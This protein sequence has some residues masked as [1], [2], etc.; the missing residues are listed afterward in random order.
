MN[1]SWTQYL[2]PFIRQRLEGR[3]GLQ[4]VVGNTGWLFANNILRMGVGLLVNIWVTRYLGPEQFGLLSYATAFVFVF[5]SIAAMGLDWVVVRNIVRDPS[6]RDEVLGTT[7][8]L[9]LAGGVITFGL[10]L[11]TIFIVRPTDPITRLLVAI[12]A[13]G[14]VFQ[15]FGTINFWFQSQV[16]SK[17]SVLVKSGAFLVVSVA[18]IALICLEAPLVAFAW[19]GLAEIVLGSVGL[20][21]AYR[22]RG[23]HLM[24]W[25]ATGTM[26]KALLRDCWPLMLTDVVMLAYLRID[27]IMLGE[28]AGN[29]EVGIYS[30]AVLLAETWLFIPMA[31]TSSLFPSVVEA[32]EHGEELFHSRL[33]KYYNLM[34]FLGYAVALPVS[35]IANWIVPLLFGT[36]YANAGPMLTGLIWAG[37]F[38]NLTIARSSYLTVMNWT[39]LHLVTDLLGCALNITLNLILIPRFGGMGAVIASLVAYWAVAHGACFLFKPLFKTGSMLTK[40]ML[41]P[42]FW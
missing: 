8:I 6:S 15:A 37:L 36:A 32:R 5:S 19:A 23:H 12:I 24:A 21:A 16:Q 1:A 2:P 40:A 17:Y 29:T 34:A 9:K 27:Q 41:Y 26:A 28:I 10:T 35:L 31:V 39:H 33:Q 11:V 20:V 7:F 42:K 22:V 13:T 3:H 14:I 4:Q 25:R 18:K 38:M 30:V